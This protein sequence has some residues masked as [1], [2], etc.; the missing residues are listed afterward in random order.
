MPSEWNSSAT[1]TDG[2]VIGIGG[3]PYNTADTEYTVKQK[4]DSQLDGYV[5]YY[6]YW[7]KN[8]AFLPQN[9]VV[10]RKNTTF[11]ISNIIN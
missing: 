4:Y 5:N 6:Y 2:A 9:S 8:S 10:D 7:V 3:T 11:Y 1:S